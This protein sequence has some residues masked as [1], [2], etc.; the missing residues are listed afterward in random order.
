MK[1]ITFTT[2]PIT[3]IASGILNLLLPIANLLHGGARN[4]LEL[5]VYEN[6]YIYKNY[7]YLLTYFYIHT[8]T[9]VFYPVFHACIRAR[10][11]EAMS[12]NRK[13]IGVL[14][15]ASNTFFKGVQK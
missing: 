7:Y 6:I 13:I 1:P 12:F 11:R 3:P 10:T 8:L 15:V 14:P 5:Q 4:R 9:H 2:Q